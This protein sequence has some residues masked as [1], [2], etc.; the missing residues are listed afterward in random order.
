M[1]ERVA[2][3][4]LE[5]FSGVASPAVSAVA[6]S[7]ISAVVG[8]EVFSVSVSFV[9]WAASLEAFAGAQSEVSSVFELSAV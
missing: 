5:R 2:S 1:A 9:P 7:G 4:P 8:H 3:L 6:Q